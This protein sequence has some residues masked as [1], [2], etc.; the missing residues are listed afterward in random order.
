MAIS[1]NRTVIL[2]PK[3]VYIIYM[4][5]LRTTYVHRQIVTPVNIFQTWCN[6]PFNGLKQYLDIIIRFLILRL[7]GEL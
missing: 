2:T 3:M 1:G 5:M 7:S 4:G 6:V